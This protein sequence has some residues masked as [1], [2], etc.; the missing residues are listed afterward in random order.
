MSDTQVSAKKRK[1]TE[2]DPPPWFLAFA[3]E[4]RNQMKEIKELQT[5]ALEI[6]REHNNLLKYLTESL[7]QKN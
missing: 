6:A 4:Q 5:A 2:Y 7:L 1:K 3:E